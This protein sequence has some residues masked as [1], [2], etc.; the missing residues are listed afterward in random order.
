MNY[1]IRIFLTP[2]LAVGE[3]WSISL[4]H[5]NILVYITC[6]FFSK[7]FQTLQNHKEFMNTVK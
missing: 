7:Y 3:L 5:L 4:F 6:K 2:I 1:F